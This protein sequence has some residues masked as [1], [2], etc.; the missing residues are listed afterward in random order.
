MPFGLSLAQIMELANEVPDLVGDIKKLAPKLT[1][2]LNQMAVTT[3][4]LNKAGTLN[5]AALTVSGVKPLL[6]EIVTG[7]QAAR[8]LLA[9]VAANPAI[10]NAMR[11]VDRAQKDGLLDDVERILTQA[12]ALLPDL[13]PL[14]AKVSHA[15]AILGSSDTAEQAKAKIAKTDWTKV[16]QIDRAGGVSSG[17]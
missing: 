4:K 10:D 16:A 12:H 13:P 2:L 15:L 17:V 11:M 5:E 1:P 8:D 7:V 9:K 3:E 6:P 14:I